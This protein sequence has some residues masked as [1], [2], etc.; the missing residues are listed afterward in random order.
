MQAS[1]EVE[2]KATKASLSVKCDEL[3]SSMAQ[4]NMLTQQTNDAVAE[5]ETARE[6]MVQLQARLAAAAA[7]AMD[8]QAL[9]T[10]AYVH[11][12]TCT[13]V[14]GRGMNG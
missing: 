8:T 2:L 10:H 13:C 11:T 5:A 14:H 9:H 6:E 4:I 12:H 7:T 1:L 3:E